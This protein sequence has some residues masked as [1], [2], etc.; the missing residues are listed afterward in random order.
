MQRKLAALDRLVTDYKVHSKGS[1]GTERLLSMLY[2]T[3]EDEEKSVRTAVV[4]S[5]RELLPWLPIQ[6]ITQ[7][8]YTIL[9][10]DP[11]KSVR[12][13]AMRVL[14]DIA[15]ERA[16]Y[17]KAIINT[18]LQEYSTTN[19]DGVQ[20]LRSVL[21]TLTESSPSHAKVFLPLILE[22]CS[23]VNPHIQVV[24][25]TSL[26]KVLKV[27]PEQVR[28]CLKTLSKVADEH[29]DYTPRE[30]RKVA[31][32]VLGC[33]AALIPERASDVFKVVRRAC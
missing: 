1:T 13:A 11:E 32:E 23:S 5:L 17:R 22:A 12:I 29:R 21:K 19:N 24:A 28:N 18:L 7:M 9:S 30:V 8:L 25:M 26:I 31:I 27:A 33:A 4:N 2:D 6:Q 3:C 15:N 16:T 14:G 10:C 20:Q